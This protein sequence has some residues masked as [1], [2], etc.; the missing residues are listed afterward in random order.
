MKKK[1][2]IIETWLVTF[3][4]ILHE[5]RHPGYFFR[6]LLHFSAIYCPER[7]L[8][9]ALYRLRGT[10]IGK[11]VFIATMVF[12]EEAYPELITIKDNV[13][14]GPGVIIV[15][16]DTSCKCISP[17]M[18]VRKEKVIIG[19]NVYIGAGAIILPGVTIGENSIIGAGAVVTGDIPPD[20]VAVG[21]PAKVVCTRDEWLENKG[22]SK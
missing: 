15:T 17:G 11:N 2:E 20:T 5:I 4:E 6:S 10:K 1:N 7:H 8:K 18:P 19:R 22:K 14:L 9:L 16:H 12:L 3:L 21:V 13:D